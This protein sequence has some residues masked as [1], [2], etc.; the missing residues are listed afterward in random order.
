[1]CIRAVDS[2]GQAGSP[3]NPAPLR[4]PRPPSIDRVTVRGSGLTGYGSAGPY[5]TS[6]K[7]SPGI[8]CSPYITSYICI[9]MFIYDI[10]ILFN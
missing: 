8:L 3:S 9:R 1:M 10:S 6:E 4:P 2:S 7:V 5:T